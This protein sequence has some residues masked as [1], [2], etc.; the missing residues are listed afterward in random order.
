MSTVV[1]RYRR[2]RWNSNAASAKSDSCDGEGRGCLRDRH[3]HRRGSAPLAHPRAHLGCRRG[4]GQVELGAK[5]RQRAQRANRVKV[6]KPLL[7]DGPV[8]R[9]GS[10][11]MGSHILAMSI[12]TPF[13]R[14]G[15]HRS[16][17]KAL[18]LSKPR[19][20]SGP[21]AFGGFMSTS[22]PRHADKMTAALRAWACMGHAFKG[23]QQPCVRSHTTHKIDAFALQSHSPPESIEKWNGKERHSGCTGAENPVELQQHRQG[24]GE[25]PAH[26]HAAARWPTALI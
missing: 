7:R 8:L 14:P 17:I 1:S 13:A 25:D 22:L 4:T 20:E 15:M 21:K 2:T 9:R 3:V 26:I 19:T 18:H 16:G 23:R 5:D 10:G 24:I 11:L 12:K 6:R